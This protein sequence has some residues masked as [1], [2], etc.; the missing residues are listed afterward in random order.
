MRSGHFSGYIETRKLWLNEKKT[1]FIRTDCGFN[2]DQGGSST[3]SVLFAITESK[4]E[5]PAITSAKVAETSLEQNKD[6]ENL[7]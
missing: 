2:D 5:K 6:S 7:K 1:L 4:K 3:G